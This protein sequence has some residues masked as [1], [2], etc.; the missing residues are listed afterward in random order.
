V[1]Q[2][3]IRETGVHVAAVSALIAASR[4]R[5]AWLGGAPDGEDSFPLTDGEHL[6][7]STMFFAALTSRS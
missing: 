1:R 7:A 5:D 3:I 6:A 4:R 2:A